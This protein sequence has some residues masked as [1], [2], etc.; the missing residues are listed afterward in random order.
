[1]YYTLYT[2]HAKN[3][4]PLHSTV[5]EK[6]RKNCLKINKNAFLVKNG[7]FLAVFLDYFKNGAL[8]RAVV[9]C[10]AFSVPKLSI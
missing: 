5:L 9:F 6:I 1:M 10:V 2:I 4:S 7:Q 3:C 8:W